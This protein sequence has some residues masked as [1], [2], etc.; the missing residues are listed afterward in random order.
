[1]IYCKA[2]HGVK[3]G[4]QFYRNRALEL[5][6]QGLYFFLQ[7]ERMFCQTS[8][9]TDI[10]RGIV[11]AQSGSWQ[12]ELEGHPNPLIGLYQGNL[13]IQVQHSHLMGWAHSAHKMDLSDGQG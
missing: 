13:P 2:N 5:I 9:L 12:S 1:M 11:N 10:R 4:W 8:S 7:R 3:K 6:G